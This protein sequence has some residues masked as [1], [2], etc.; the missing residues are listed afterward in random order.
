MCQIRVERQ[1]FTPVTVVVAYKDHRFFFRKIPEN[2]NFN[3]RPMTQRF[4]KLKFDL[5]Q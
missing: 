3:I 5:S 4:R 1:D 2:E